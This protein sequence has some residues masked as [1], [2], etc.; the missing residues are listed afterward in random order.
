MVSIGQTVSEE[1]TFK[2][3]P[4]GSYVKTMSADSWTSW[5]AD[6][7]GYNSEKRPPK[8]HPSKFGLNSPNGFRGDF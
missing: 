3:F 6:F 5:L 1:K 4:Q 2:H 7:I 8:D